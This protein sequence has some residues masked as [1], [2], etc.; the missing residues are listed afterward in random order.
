MVEPIK[1][2][3]EFDLS[4]ANRQLKE[5]EDREGDVREKAGEVQIQIVQ[6]EKR[7]DRLKQIEA[8]V[9]ASAKTVSGQLFQMGAASITTDLLSESFGDD[10]TASF[11]GGGVGVILQGAAIGGVPG[12]LGAGI[13]VAFQGMMMLWRNASNRIAKIEKDQRDADLRV[14]ALVEERRQERARISRESDVKLK[15][16]SDT[17]RSELREEINVVAAEIVKNQGLIVGAQN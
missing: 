1:E 13:A 12:A 5:V 4:K 7:I 17:F 8:T 16:L 11:V 14:D 2:E 10:A 3:L 15:E 9:K 6:S